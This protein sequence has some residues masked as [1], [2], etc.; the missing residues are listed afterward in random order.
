VL[1]VDD[2]ASVCEVLTRAFTSHGWDVQMASTA[3]EADD[4]STLSD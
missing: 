3:E 2:D 4:F 1:V